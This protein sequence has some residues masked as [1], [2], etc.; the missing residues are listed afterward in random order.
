LELTHW[1]VRTLQKVAARESIGPRVHFTTIGRVLREATL[2]PHR[3]RYWKTTRWDDTAVERAAQVL[4]CYERAWEWWEQG[5]LVVCMDEK[6]NLQALERA[7]PGYPMRPGWIERQ[8]FEYIR[9]GTVHLLVGL[10]VHDGQMWAECLEAN[11]G[12]HFRAALLRYWA[13]WRGYVG[14][15]LIMD[16][17]PSHGAAETQ[18]LCRELRDPWVQ[19]RYTPPRASWLNQ[20]ELL[21]GAFSRRYLRRGSWGSRQALI[22]HIMNSVREYNEFFAHPF[23]WSWTSQDLRHWVER[24]HLSIRCNTSATHH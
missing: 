10:T 9:H 13:R 17:G 15:Y 2:Q 12:A 8:E 20:A 11:D 5:I 4:E 19:V 1:S 24:K 3:W 23:R 7:G 18:A 16:N 6:P 14:I 21:L 22:D